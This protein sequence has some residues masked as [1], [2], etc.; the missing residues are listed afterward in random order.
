VIEIGSRAVEP[1]E[2]RIADATHTAVRGDRLFVE[3]CGAPGSGKTTLLPVLEELL[4]ERGYA[5][6]RPEKAI[7]DRIAASR[8]A[9][10]L[11]RMHLDPGL[12]R[13]RGRRFVVDPPWGLAALVD[14]P[15]LYL[16]AAGAVLRDAV[17]WRHRVVLLHRFWLPL[18]RRRFL[19]GRLGSGEAVIFDEGP[20]H[21]AVNLFGWRR[22]QAPAAE[23]RGYARGLPV[24]DLL[25]V[26]RAAPETTRTRLLERGLPQYLRDRS[27]E[28]VSRFVRHAGEALRL[29]I[30]EV[31]Q[32]TS[33][34]TVENDGALA[35]ARAGLAAGLDAAL[36][37]RAARAGNSA[38]PVFRPSVPIRLP[39]PDRAVA[40]WRSHR[41][42]R[43]DPIDLAAV[44]EDYPLRMIGRPSRVGRGRSRNA[45]VDTDR[46]RVVVKRYK[47]SVVDD[48]IGCEH[49]VL[50]QL[51][52]INLPAP[53]LV[54]GRD[55]ETF[56]RVGG[57]RF[58]VFHHLAG[59]VA[60]HERLAWPGE[61]GRLAHL[62]GSTLAG[63]HAGLEGFWPETLN[64]IGL[65][66]DHRRLLA[67]AWHVDQL[68]DGDSPATPDEQDIASAA[69]WVA[70]RL[71]AAE[72][73]LIAAAP[74]VTVVH[75]DY[76]PYNL[77]L[78]PG[79]PLVPIDFELARPDWRLVDLASGLPRFAGSR[80]RFDR[81]RARE[82]VD[83]YLEADGIER[84]ELRLLPRV[85]EYLALRRLAVC[86]SRYVRGGDRDAL[87]EARDRLASA[88]ELAAGTHPLAR[89]ASW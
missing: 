13:G 18:A 12:A 68:P 26:V 28:E 1:N 42:E 83:G 25:V 43:A 75:G 82:F 29:A 70:E 55:G 5:P 85:A 36:A 44:L 11:A 54:H 52:R 20:V 10:A 71:L 39:R 17:T 56:V 63:L 62:A 81:R 88:R 57:E 27:D 35:E 37:S 31:G 87:A 73:E 14:R 38:V 6:V 61:P 46:G 24:P 77:L 19:Q 65:G 7:D 22:H 40:A 59:Y 4:R 15:S 21:R 34:V 23:I 32:H 50:A 9:Q 72:D 67:S 79:D 30:G 48:A 80:L 47:R 78:R 66:R 45:T 60:G 58:A 86:W 89:L 51:S 76:G 49:A 84:S 74:A 33:V 69:G 16:R 64:P 2:S 41:A 53:R 3:I 8:T